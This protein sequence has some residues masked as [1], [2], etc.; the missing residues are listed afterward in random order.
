MSSDFPSQYQVPVPAPVPPIPVVPKCNRSLTTLFTQE[1]LAELERYAL[2]F[3][4]FC[5]GG[6]GARTLYL[7][8]G[9]GSGYAFFS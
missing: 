2:C 6:H 9:S 4:C 1:S 5:V 3:P 7:K 8:H